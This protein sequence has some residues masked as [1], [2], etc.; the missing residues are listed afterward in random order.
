MVSKMIEINKL[1]KHLEISDT[2]SNE[3]SDESLSSK[4]LSSDEESVSTID[5]KEE[6][7]KL[8]NKCVNTS[9]STTISVLKNHLDKKFQ[10]ASQKF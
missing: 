10:E 5:Y 2:G 4:N 7:S 6:I 3:D 9:D 1:S 8:I